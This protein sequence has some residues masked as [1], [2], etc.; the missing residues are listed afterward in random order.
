MEN[1]KKIK[2][3]YRKRQKNEY[4]TPII[5]KTNEKQ[6]NQPN[7]PR[8]K[9]ILKSYLVTEQEASNFF[10]QKDYIDIYSSLF[11]LKNTEDYNQIFSF[12]NET[13]HQIIFS[14]IKNED[15]NSNEIGKIKNIITFLDNTEKKIK[16]LKD[17]MTTNKLRF[18]PEISASMNNKLNIYSIFTEI[19]INFTE[20]ISKAEN[21]FLESLKSKKE[22]QIIL[23]VL[24][25]FINI[26]KKISK[27]K[28]LKNFSEKIFEIKK[29][30]GKYEQIYKEIF[31]KLLKN[32]EQG[33]E[34]IVKY[35]EL[36]N[37]EAEKDYIF[38]KNLF[39]EKEAMKYKEKIINIYLFDK[40]LSA[41]FSNNSILFFIINE[42]KYDILKFIETKT[43]VSAKLSNSFLEKYSNLLY[44][45]YQKFQNLPRNTKDIISGIK[46]INELLSKIKELNE[47]F[48]NVFAL[49]TKAKYKNKEIITKLSQT[50]KNGETVYFL[51]VYVNEYLNDKI[52]RD[53]FIYNEAFLQLLSNLSDKEI[54]FNYH[55]KYLFKRIS[56][57]KFNL[58]IEKNF[59]EYLNKNFEIR[60]TMNIDKIF[61]DIK[62]NEFINDV[63]S[64]NYFY[65]FS[66]NALNQNY[67]LL[68]IVEMDKI[69]K[70]LVPFCNNIAIYNVKYPKRKIDLSQ[71]LTSIE[72]LFLNKYSILVNYIQYLIL[73]TILKQKNYI[74]PY[75]KIFKLIPHKSERKTFLKLYIDSLIEIKILIKEK[76]NLKL[77][78]S[79]KTNKENINLINCFLKPNTLIK[80]LIK[81]EEGNEQNK[82]NKTYNIDAIKVNTKH[83][84]DCIIMKILKALPRGE[85]LNENKIVGCVMNHESIK[86]L[87]MVKRGLV[88]VPVI[89]G[90]INALV[91][92]ECIKLN[93][94]GGNLSYSYC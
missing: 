6:Q 36:I 40:F 42:K 91:E 74:V 69:E 60:Y 33:G 22:D 4:F 8:I 70:K 81:K 86:N 9:E 46:Y 59:I 34:L 77:N 43:R 44:S 35:F 30:M 37:L 68:Q 1:P 71:I 23:V 29:N 12:I 61:K 48:K 55:K 85:S 13:L 45:K 38:Y 26:L 90:R 24:Q 28:D 63:N 7:L 52:K 11:L 83:I 20:F 15:K 5:S 47:N 17:I 75:E 14:K 76:E 54:F 72:V 58:G 88:D 31:E 39:S 49:N 3:L 53:N 19:N 50:S 21:E 41:L 66:S 67:D 25:K 89:K 32:K 87:K 82:E 73:M 62:E 56:N 2:I 92:R 80:G 27:Y 93:N 16:T 78:L 10:T 64:P 84:I 51:S 65:L 57:N 79:F 94:K 18:N